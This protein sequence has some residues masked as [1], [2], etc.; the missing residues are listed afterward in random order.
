M[1]I[2]KTHGRNYDLARLLSAI[3]RGE[4]VLPEFQREFVWDTTAVKQLIATCLTGWPIGSLLLLPGKS[5]IFFKVREFYSAPPAKAEFQL[6]VLDGQQRLTSLYQALYGRG[7]FLYGIT[8]ASLRSDQSIEELEDALVSVPAER[9]RRMYPDPK[10]EYKAGLVP[11]TV[12]RQAS[13][14]YQWRD[15]ALVGEPSDERERLTD[16]Y[17]SLLSGLD[18]YEVPAVVIDDDVHP[19]AVARIFERVNRLGQ[20]LGTFDLVVAK[21]FTP[22]FNLRDEWDRAQIDRPRLADFL[23]GDGLPVLS[24]IA[25]QV[26]GSLRQ[27]DVLQLTGASVRD[28]WRK[29]VDSLDQAIAYMQ[30]QLGI[31]K[32]DWLPYKAQLSVVG[33]LALNHVLEMNRENVSRW[34][35]TSVFRGRYDVASNTRAVED[36]DKLAKGEASSVGEI[37]LDPEVLFAANRRQFGAIHRG[38]ICLMAT[39]DPIDPFTHQQ[40]RTVVDDSD[41]EAIPITFLDREQTF[42]GMP[43]HLLTLGMVLTTKRASRGEGRVSLGDLDSTVLRSQLM[44][45]DAASLSPAVLFG[46]RLELVA[47]AIAA[48]SGTPT[49]IAEVAAEPSGG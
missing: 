38:L 30:T 24:V 10:S 8:F 1:G 2:E 33:C 13:D 18:R 37:L 44:P 17:V 16:L 5:K 42:S 22:E 48:V 40:L 49:R 36:Y 34:F 15:Q 20:P 46:Q 32:P 39:N 19:E 21:S 7:D 14:F 27:H 31:W 11:V 47:R 25:L 43:G 3:N 4:I 26:R 9:W 41:E 12:L 6:V 45:T 29:A 28:Y 23:R 35:W